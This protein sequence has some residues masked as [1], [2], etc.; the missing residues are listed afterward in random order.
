VDLR[1]FVSNG[2][3][4]IA[5]TMDDRLNWHLWTF[6]PDG[7]IREMAQLGDMPPNE[8]TFA[9]QF[10]LGPAGVVMTDYEGSRFY[11]GVPTS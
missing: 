4:G 11:L 6:E 8:E 3:R 9:A 10:A 5:T 1:E 2:S 7:S